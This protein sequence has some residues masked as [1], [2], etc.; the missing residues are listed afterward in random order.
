MR[1]IFLR[2]VLRITMIAL[3]QRKPPQDDTNIPTDT[4]QEPCEPTPRKDKTST[5]TATK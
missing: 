1:M 3:F 5:P 4:L 2:L